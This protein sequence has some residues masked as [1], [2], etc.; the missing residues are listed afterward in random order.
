MK[1][2]F[3]SSSPLSVT[4]SKLYYRGGGEGCKEDDGRRKTEINRD[5]EKD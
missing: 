4:S 1:D 3:I 2:R 5:I